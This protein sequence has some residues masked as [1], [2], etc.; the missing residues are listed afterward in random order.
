MDL[1]RQLVWHETVNSLARLFAYPNRT[2]RYYPPLSFFVSSF[3]KTH[4][5][6]RILPTCMAG[7]VGNGATGHGLQ[8]NSPLLSQ[9]RGIVRGFATKTAI[10]LLK[11]GF[12]DGWVATRGLKTT[13]SV[14]KWEVEIGHLQMSEVMRE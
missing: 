2:G 12:R 14:V 10:R 5:S 4:A 13:C 3:V 9:S 7:S 1:C 6:L 8:D 11:F